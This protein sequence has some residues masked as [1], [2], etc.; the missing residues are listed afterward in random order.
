MVVGGAQLVVNSAQYIAED[1]IGIEPEIVALTVVAFGTSLPE[2]VT[3]VSAAKK[4]DVGIATGNII[5][6]NIAN[7]LFIGGLGSLCSGARLYDEQ[8]VQRRQNVYGAAH[9]RNIQKIKEENK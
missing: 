4:G 1:L 7:I 5:G 6:S 3:S 8:R 9:V 2:L